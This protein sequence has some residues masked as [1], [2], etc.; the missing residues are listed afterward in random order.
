MRLWDALVD[1]AEASDFNNRYSYNNGCIHGRELSEDVSG[2]VDELNAVIADAI[3]EMDEAIMFSSAM[4]EWERQHRP[5]RRLRRHRRDHSHRYKHKVA[6]L[7]DSGDMVAN[8][9]KSTLRSRR[10]EICPM[11]PDDYDQALRDAIEEDNY[12]DSE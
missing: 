5:P 11:L 8:S 7:Y 10:G 1:Y 12:G 6:L 3:G 4:D 9:P 2:Y